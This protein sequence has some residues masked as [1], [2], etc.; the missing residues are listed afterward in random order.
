MPRIK[1]IY[2][3]NKLEMNI[4]END[5]LISVMKIYSDYITKDINKLYFLY[6]GKSLKLDSELK[7]NQF[8]KINIIISVFNIK[9]SND[10]KILNQIVCPKCANLACLNINDK[11]FS[12]SNCINHHIINNISLKGLINNFYINENLIKCKLCGNK[13]NLYDNIYVN[14]DNE[15]ICLLCRKSHITVPYYIIDNN[16]YYNCFLHQ[17]IF[18]SYCQKCNQNLCDKC[19]ENHKSHNIIT[20]KQI[21]P[22]TY[23]IDEI[24][25][26]LNNSLIN[27]ELFKNE[28]L[29][30]NDILNSNIS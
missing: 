17:N 7:I 23:K 4:N 27:I 5:L 21:M 24:K 22:N 28:I 20:F 26:N 15:H 18:S 25:Q 2:G 6:K 3:N 14:K 9:N 12:I 8:K 13:K 16:K 30:I 19:E 1:F 11:K 10:K 29:I